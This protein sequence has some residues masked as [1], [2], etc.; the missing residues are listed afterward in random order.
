VLPALTDAERDLDELMGS[1]RRAGARR[2]FFNVLFLRSP[3]KEKYLR[4]LSAEF[5]RFLA[6]Y[7]RAYAGRV[8]LGGGYRRWI[9]Q[10]ISRLREKH[11]LDERL[12]EP[13]F[14]PR[15]AAA[16]LELWP[17]AS[18]PSRSAPVLESGHE[19]AETRT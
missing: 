12:T 5:P 14:T 11:G 9:E 13:A 8:Y 3:T 6:A 10:R 18:L 17:Q 15:P 4:W 7:Q 19:H 16:Q 1:A 2:M